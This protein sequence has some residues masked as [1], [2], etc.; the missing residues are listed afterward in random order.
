YS[1]TF[2]FNG[3]TLGGI[4]LSYSTFNFN[5][6]A[7]GSP[8]TL[9]NSSLNIATTKAGSFVLQGSDSLSGNIAAGQTLTVQANSNYSANLYV[10]DGTVND[11]TIYLDDTT[12]YNYAQLSVNGTLTNAADG[13]IEALTDGGGYRYFSGNLLNQG[14]VTTDDG[15]IQLPFDYSTIT[16]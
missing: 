5:G 9:V 16:F 1:D 2:N 8:V 15:G 11:G 10:P 13:T 3:G 14:T 4:A 6:G 12:Y 7:P